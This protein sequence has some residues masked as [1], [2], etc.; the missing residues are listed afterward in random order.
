MKNI[1]TQRTANEIVACLRR[2]Y[3]SLFAILVFL[4]FFV[5]TL[6]SKSR[7]RGSG[8]IQILQNRFPSVGDIWDS[9]EIV[10]INTSSIWHVLCHYTGRTPQ[11]TVSFVSQT[12][13]WFR[14]LRVF[15]VFCR[16]L[17][18]TFPGNRAKKW[19]RGIFTFGFF[20]K[21]WLN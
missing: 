12:E 14:L 1:M 8:G 5:L 4:C 19:C 15:Y 21:L 13:N 9:F 10:A 16:N 7:A 17:K 11:S 6:V 3:A 2:I 20:Q 18:R